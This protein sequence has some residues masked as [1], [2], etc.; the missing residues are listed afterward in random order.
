MSIHG[1][2]TPLHISQ[3]V[4]HKALGVPL[5]YVEA[6]DQEGNR[7]VEK[8]ESEVNSM[9]ESLYLQGM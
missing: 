5:V 8:V 9:Q 2:M 4:A 6:V 3:A 7:V 1:S